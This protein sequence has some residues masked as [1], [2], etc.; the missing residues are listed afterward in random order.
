M[1]DKFFPYREEEKENTE[2]RVHGGHGGRM[3]ENADPSGLTA[4]PSASLRAGCDDKRRQR[5]WIERFV[6]ERSWFERGWFHPEFAKEQ[7]LERRVA[8]VSVGKVASGFVFGV[9]GRVGCGSY[10][11][12]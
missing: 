5:S 3:G 9:A 11:C 6:D 12:R 2:F 1:L 4:L 7:G 10:F 8:A